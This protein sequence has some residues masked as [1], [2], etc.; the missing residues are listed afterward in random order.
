MSREAGVPECQV[1]PAR[2]AVGRGCQGTQSS[3]MRTHAP[4]PVP[5]DALSLVLL[6]PRDGEEDGG[7]SRTRT[8]N[9]RDFVLLVSSSTR[10]NGT[11]W[12]LLAAGTESVH[13][14]T[15]LEAGGRGVLGKSFLLPWPRT[16]WDVSLGMLHRRGAGAPAAWS[17]WGA[18]GT[19]PGL[20]THPRAQLHAGLPHLTTLLCGGSLLA[21]NCPSALPPASVPWAVLRILWGPWTFL[22]T[23]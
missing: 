9:L 22:H 6:R 12:T 4:L 3:A 2:R 19:E 1:R 13:H 23:A 21:E 16:H 7:R 8:W 15:A 10:R 14:N 17:C 5:R 18:V 20:P 11:E